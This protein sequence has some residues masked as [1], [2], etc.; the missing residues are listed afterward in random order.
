MPSKGLSLSNYYKK[1]GLSKGASEQE[2]KKAYRKLA[3]KYH[4]DRNAGSSEHEEKFKEISE[5]YAV[6]SD[7]EKK[8]QYDTF[9]STQFHQRYSADD[10]FQG[11]DFSSIFNDLGFGGSGRGQSGDCNIGPCLGERQGDAFTD[12]PARANN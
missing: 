8:K 6:L 10:I 7:P 4:P 11:A 1:L 12:S 5:A 3:M 2:I 9:G